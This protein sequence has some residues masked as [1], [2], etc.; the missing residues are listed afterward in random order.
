MKMKK[1]LASLLVCAAVGTTGALIGCDKVKADEALKAAYDTYVVAMTDA[2]K[3]ALSYEDWVKE[4]QKPTPDPAVPID[5]EQELKAVYND[6]AAKAG[7][8]AV[9]YATWKSAVT[10]VNGT[11][12]NLY[13]DQNGDIV[14]E[15]TNGT[16]QVVKMPIWHTIKAVDQFNEP[17]AGAKIIVCDSTYC[18]DVASGVTNED[19]ELRVAFVPN[20]ELDYFAAASINEITDTPYGYKNSYEKFAIED[21]VATVVYEY[22][23]NDVSLNEHIGIELGKN[24]VTVPADRYTYFDFE[25]EENGYYK[26]VVKLECDGWVTEYVDNGWNISTDG[27]GIPTEIADSLVTESTSNGVI[28]YTFRYNWNGYGAS[29]AHYYAYAEEGA[30]ITVTATRLSDA[31]EPEPAN[32]A[33]TSKPAATNIAAA[34]TVIGDS[35][36]EMY[37]TISDTVILDYDSL[38]TETVIKITED[39]PDITKGTDGYYHVGDKNGPILMVNLTNA[40]SWL[41]GNKNVS[42][43]EA[44]DAGNASDDTYA[45]HHTVYTYGDDSITYQKIYY[46]LAL[47]AYF[48]KVNSEGY[49]PVNDELK[50]I[51]ESYQGD[52]TTGACDKSNASWLH[53]CAYYVDLSFGVGSNQI[54]INAESKFLSDQ[55]LN[56]E[57]D[58]VYITL[59]AEEFTDGSYYKLTAPAGISFGFMDAA[60][61]TT[62]AEHSGKSAATYLFQYSSL[63]IYSFEQTYGSISGLFTIEIAPATTAE[64]KASKTFADGKQV[65]TTTSAED[66]LYLSGLKA[67]TYTIN[68]SGSDVNAMAPFTFSIT[69]YSY[70]AA[71]EEWTAGEPISFTLEQGTIN[72]LCYA[73]ITIV[74]PANDYVVIN[75]VNNMNSFPLQTNVTAA[76][77]EAND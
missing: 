47:A 10:A 72:T 9:D 33:S 2:G 37:L 54:V 66:K 56:G 30:E 35:G 15:F 61:Y 1:L 27:E 44:H 70:D 21:G 57:K 40:T 32:P 11:G 75:C 18:M 67:G 26:V 50:E 29:N 28:T 49:Y 5:P 62:I 6:Y 65:S 46:D 16:S 25:V 53:A 36:D 24:D 31:I 76:A 45:F 69:Y 23:P 48:E 42:I 74:D 63:A 77:T 55:F 58:N 8:A 59:D 14:V 39:V 60:S 71:S 22:R 41:N 34:N 7:D 4:I 19:G 52:Y 43:K 17:V 12:N 51:L 13:V 64:I 20:E 68:L 38:E 3:T 73:S